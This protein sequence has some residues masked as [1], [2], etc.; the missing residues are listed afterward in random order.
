MFVF[1]DIKQGMD[2]HAPIHVGVDKHQSSSFYFIST[3]WH[4][5]KTLTFNELISKFLHINPYT[6]PKDASNFF[7][8]QT[9]K[10][11]YVGNNQHLAKASVELKGNSIVSIIHIVMIQRVILWIALSQ[12]NL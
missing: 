3:T 4:A 9:W 10:V 8:K 2:D 1:F 11:L 12:Y 5:K 7:I 6:D